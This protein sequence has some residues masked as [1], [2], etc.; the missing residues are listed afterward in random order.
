MTKKI[1]DKVR[2]GSF[3]VDDAG[4][5]VF[6]K[7]RSGVVEKVFQDEFGIAYAVRRKGKTE[8]VLDMLV[9]P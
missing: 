9:K 7:D 4:I 1:G 6:Q 5:T 8:I 3:R 2:Y